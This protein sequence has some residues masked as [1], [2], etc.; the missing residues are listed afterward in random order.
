MCNHENAKPYYYGYMS[1]EIM[2]DI[3]N[4]FIYY[5]GMHKTDDLPSY[6]CKDCLEDIWD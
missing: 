4:G 6:F 5:G 2:N 3:N 1:Y